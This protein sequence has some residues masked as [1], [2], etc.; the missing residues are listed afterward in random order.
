[1]WVL[2]LPLAAQQFNGKVVDNATRKPVEFA[3]VFLHDLQTGTAADINGRFSFKG[4]L[5]RQ[6]KIKVSAIGYESV[7]KI[8]QMPQTDT[9][10]IA[11]E[12]MH[13]ELSEVTISAATG[14]LQKHAVTNIESKTLAELNTINTTNLGEAISNIP[15]VYQTSTGVGISKPV[16]RGLSGIRVVTYLNG[17][18]LENQQWGGDHGMGVTE[19]G[20]GNVEVIKGPASLLYGADALGGVVYFTD[21]NFAS[22]NESEAFA[23]SSFESNSMRTKNFAGYKVSKNNIRLNVLGNYANNADYRLPNGKFA[24]NSRFKE[25]NLK[26]NLGYNKKNW[27][28]NVRYNFMN[29]HVGIPGHTHDTIITPES[30]H[31][32][33]QIRKTIIPVQVITNHYLLLENSFYFKNSDLKIYL[34]NTNNRLR[35]F[36]EKVTIPGLDISLNN[37][38]YNTRWRKSLTEK[39]SFIAGLQGMFQYNSNGKEATETLIPDATMIDNGAYTVLQTE[40]KKWEIMTGIRFDNRTIN[41][42]EIVPFSGGYYGF[43]YSAGFSR[44]FKKILVRAN[45]SSGYRPPHTSEL[46]SNG[47]HHGTLRY[48]I[49]NRG[50]G[51]E[52]ATQIDMSAEY[53]TDHVSVIVNPFYN[54]IRDYIYLKPTGTQMENLPVY[55]YSQAKYAQLMGGDIGIHY[56]PHFAHRFHLENSVSYIVAEDQLGQALPLVPQTRFNTQLRFEMSGT[57]KIRVE[58]ISVQHLYFLKQDRVVTYETISPAYQ[59][60]NIGMNM[61]MDYKN[62]IYIKLGIKNLLNEKY[63][64]HL[65]RLKNIGLAS[66]GINFYLSVKINFVNKNN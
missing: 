15:G 55:I 24:Q 53:K 20:I 7:V 34:G 4:E 47:I 25:N 29:N 12:P 22:Q 61:K 40:V 16:I 17:Q 6:L 37:T 14:T 43:N 56:H 60:I 58:N 42:M 26:V 63:I 41:T 27:V 2:C 59:L 50:L 46:L 66:P 57:K 19:N 1:M 18:R 32:D 10:L 33:R 64:D 28:L 49:G 51:T 54:R 65:S 3:T 9:L 44:T 5:P 11:L 62:P 39:T 30:F 21:E 23:E 31:T 45:L 48:E 36:E 38:T 52:K 35:E 13:I 8:L